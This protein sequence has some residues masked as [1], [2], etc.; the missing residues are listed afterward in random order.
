MT[1]VFLTSVLKIIVLNLNVISLCH[2]PGSNFIIL[3]VVMIVT[4]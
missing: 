3:M 1:Y 2:L 4:A